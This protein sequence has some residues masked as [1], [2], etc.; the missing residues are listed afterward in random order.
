M[1]GFSPTVGCTAEAPENG[2]EAVSPLLHGLEDRLATE[3][4]VE[5]LETHDGHVGSRALEL[6]LRLDPA[7]RSGYAIRHPMTF[8][9]C[10]SSAAV[11][12]WRSGAAML[13]S[14]SIA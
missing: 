13:A 1:G 9:R 11:L 8:E 14:P 7:G 10:G 6:P 12:G 5:L 2:A 4:H 3:G